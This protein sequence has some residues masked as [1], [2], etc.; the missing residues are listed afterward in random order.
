MRRTVKLLI[1]ILSLLALTPELALAQQPSGQ[2]GTPNQTQAVKVPGGIYVRNFQGNRALFLEMLAEGLDKKGLTMVE[3]PTMAEYV[4]DLSLTQVGQ[5]QRYNSI[6]VYRSWGSISINPST[7]AGLFLV[8]VMT[9]KDGRWVKSLSTTKPIPVPTNSGSN[10][11]ISIGGVSVG[12]SSGYSWSDGYTL[13]AAQ[14]IK[15]VYGL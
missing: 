2:W 13:A 8:S 12:S 10:V 5:G 1:S 3:D 11:W 6:S 7:G 15:K 14:A 4:L 9:W